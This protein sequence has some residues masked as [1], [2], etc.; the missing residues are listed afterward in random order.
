MLPS[1]F[2]ARTTSRE[3]SEIL[4]AFKLDEEDRM[5]AQLQA[6]AN[7]NLPKPK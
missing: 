4:V 5:Q 7:A 3:M 1:E 6:E 2:L